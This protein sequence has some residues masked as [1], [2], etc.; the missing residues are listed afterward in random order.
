MPPTPKT[1]TTK[2]Q[3]LALAER[4]KALIKLGHY[5]AALASFDEAVAL[6]RAFLDANQMRGGVLF[7]LGRYEAALAS[8]DAVVALDP[9][10]AHGWT[11]R[12][13]A[14]M[15]MGRPQDALESFRR[16][17]QLLPGNAHAYYDLGCALNELGQYEAAVASFDKAIALNPRHAPACNNKAVALA[18]LGHCDAALACHEA[19]IRLAPALAD[20]HVNFGVTLQLLGRHAAATDRYE[21][22]VAVAPDNARAHWNLALCSLLLGDFARGWR[23]FEWR[24][25]Y[26]GVPDDRL[27][28]PRWTGTQ[29]LQGKTIVLDA[30]QGLGD[31]LQF[32][33]YAEPLAQLG[34]SVI[35][36]VPRPLV[37]L[38]ATVPGAAGAIA[39]DEPLPA[40][41]FRCP[42]M[43][44]PLALKTT[45]ETIPARIPYL[46][47]DAAKCA[48][49][50][51]RIGD[52]GG[53]RVGLVWSG[54]FRADQPDTWEVNRRRNVPLAK[55][56]ALAL[57]GVRFFSLQ[58]GEEAVA[59][60]RELQATRGDPAIAD[61]T[62]ELHDF[63]DT[64]ALV[65][66]LDLVVSVDTATAHLAGALGKEVWLLN[67]FDTCWRWLLDRRD[68]PWYPGLRLFRQ[69]SPG[70]WDGVVAAVRAALAERLARD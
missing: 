30:E 67:R 41:D 17:A 39:E 10:F 68:S 64:A 24:W 54:G 45:L 51:Q 27:P 4:G 23:E 26:R 5:E 66:N 29:S 3:A 13:S 11:S 18:A 36:R 62:A 6:D 34:A 57:P 65:D 42:M 60:L 9:R 58:K 47:S 22:A 59:Q 2:A 44:A 31:T 38:L 16:A 7:R 49:W 70:D 50:A 40:F 1:P 15:R 14:L 53:L 28:Q 61:F 37:G 48:R 32:C 63:S 52:A 46:H 35:L 69:A 21:Q 8:F 43:S 56:A 19:A 25:R 20:G 12:G 55:L 33:R